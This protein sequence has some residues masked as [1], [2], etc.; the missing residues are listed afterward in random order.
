MSRLKLLFLFAFALSSLAV[1]KPVSDQ[2]NRFTVNVPDDWTLRKPQN[3]W[4]N[5]TATTCV[6]LNSRT[7]ITLTLDQWAQR[8]TQRNDKV[9]IFSD[10]LA[11]SPAK[12]VEFATADGSLSCA[13][14]ARK[15]NVGAV[16][17]LIYSPQTPGI[18]ELKKKLAASYK[19]VK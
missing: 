17:T 6:S 14:I 11:G 12:R 19:W 9:K 13:W 1:A 15:G 10:K 4:A 5:K 3:V 16:V 18:P 8:I 7:P 2:G